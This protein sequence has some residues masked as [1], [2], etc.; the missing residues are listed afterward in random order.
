MNRFFVSKKQDNYFI[1][2]NDT[3][4]HLRVI[5]VNDKP[6][7]CVYQE[8]FYECVLEFE[9]A[10]IIKKLRLN[11]ER[12]NKVILAVALIKYERFEW[13]LQKAVELGVSEIQPMLTDYTNGELYQYQKYQK[14]IQRFKTIIQNAAEQSFRN[15]IPELL[16]LKKFDDVIQQQNLTKYLSHE[17]LL[18]SEQIPQ[19]IKIDVM[20]LVGPEGGFSDLEITKARENKVHLVS[21]GKRILRAETAAIFMLSQLKID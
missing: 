19:S 10:K 14:R 13:L 16:E 6:F 20:F 12:N 17:K 11:N 21:L 2:N 9:K 7:I 5:R 4:K 8:E 15:K 1:L 18:I 3:L